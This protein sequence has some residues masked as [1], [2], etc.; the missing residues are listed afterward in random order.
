MAKLFIFLVFSCFVIVASFVH[1]SHAVQFTVTNTALGTPGGDRFR[2]EVGAPYAR[3]VLNSSTTFIWRLLQE[4][5][6][7][8]RKNIQT[9]SMFVDDMDGVAY[10]SN[11][12][13]HVSAR[14]FQGLTGDVRRGISG[15]LYHE[16]TH[17]WQWNGN[18]QAPGGL[19]EGVADYVRLKAGYVP[20]HWVKPGQ[21]NRWDQGYD[22][23]ARFLDYCNGLKPGFV[24]QLN[25]LMRNGY[26]DNF[27]VQLLGKP[28]N[29]LWADYKAKFNT[30]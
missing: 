3:T 25:K 4:N 20:S 27:F 9:V 26:N 10:T 29:Q 23:T 2:A 30:N 12:Q 7:A 16:M 6:P 1:G 28:V 14:W 5:A 17:V 19:I 15:V 18:G 21:G 22:V 8:D 24:A 13:I 11:D